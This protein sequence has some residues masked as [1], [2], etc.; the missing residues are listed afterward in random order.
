MAGSLG[1]DYK[2]PVVGTFLNNWAFSSQEFIYLL[3]S[4][5]IYSPSH[6]FTTR[7]ILRSLF[8]INNYGGDLILCKPL[9][10]LSAFVS[11]PVQFT[12]PVNTHHTVAGNTTHTWLPLRWQGFIQSYF[13]QYIIFLIQCFLAFLV[14]TV[15]FS[16]E[17]QC[18][19]LC[20]FRSFNCLSA[21]RSQAA[22]SAY[23]CSTRLRCWTRCWL[24]PNTM[25]ERYRSG[26]PARTKTSPGCPSLCWPADR[27]NRRWV[28][29]L[30][31]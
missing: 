30:L 22:T 6:C 15:P 24:V 18:F 26:E 31:V 4:V 29:L 8:S 11:C 12:L 5:F 7:H 2:L 25:R 3:I 27:D 28:T 19:C 14:I 23:G 16:T 10:M 13:L 21:V 17:Y 20:H 1:H 9:L